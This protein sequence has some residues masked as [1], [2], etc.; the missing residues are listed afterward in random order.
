MGGRTA[1]TPLT[2]FG[3]AD[4]RLIE[5]DF[6]PEHRRDFTVRKQVLWE[7]ANASPPEVT[8]VEAELIRALRSNDPAIGYNRCPGIS[9]LPGNRWPDSAVRWP[10]AHRLVGP[11]RCR[12]SSKNSSS[13]C[14]KSKVSRTVTPT[15]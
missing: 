4:S 12:Q 3:S 2:Y 5:Q 8:R 11:L 1:R 15:W 10:T 14:F 9:R 7:S 6:T 13:I